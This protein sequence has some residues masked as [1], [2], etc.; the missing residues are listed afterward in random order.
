[1]K[2]HFRWGTNPRDQKQVTGNDCDV[3]S[4]LEVSGKTDFSNIFLF[5]YKQRT[6]VPFLGGFISSQ[7][8]ND[9]EICFPSQ[10]LPVTCFWSRSFGNRGEISL[11]CFVKTW[12]RKIA[13]EYILFCYTY[14]YHYIVEI[15]SSKK[16]VIYAL[17]SRI[18][19]L[20]L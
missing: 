19:I 2:F 17:K 18:N 1:M 16:I 14:M 3:I 13:I 7:Y 11:F 15:L 10:L 5:S 6:F 20:I 12:R 9:R 4:G 8:E